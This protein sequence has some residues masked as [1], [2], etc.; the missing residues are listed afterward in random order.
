MHR[1]SAVDEPSGFQ[2][3]RWDGER[4]VTHTGMVRDPATI[5]SVDLG[6]FVAE[7]RKRAEIGQPFTK[8]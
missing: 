3:H 5:R 7:I 1:L 4:F 6:P 2:L 8:N